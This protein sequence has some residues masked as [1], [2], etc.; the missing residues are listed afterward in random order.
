[1]C[2]RNYPTLPQ[3]WICHRFP[4]ALKL[5]CITVTRKRERLRKCIQ[6]VLRMIENRE[7]LRVLT[8][9]FHTSPYMHLGISRSI[10]I[11]ESL[12]GEIPF[13][14]AIE[15]E[16]GVRYFN[17]AAEALQKRADALLR[18][19]R[20]DRAKADLRKAVGYSLAPRTK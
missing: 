20:W 2:R 12:H 15:A 5:S 19:A 3:D 16:D 1:M 17:Q 7:P 10:V 4:L 9:K 14:N 11:I 18:Q 6:Q 8:L 13:S